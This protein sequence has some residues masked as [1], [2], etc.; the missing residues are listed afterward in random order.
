[1]I[2]TTMEEKK[3]PNFFAH[4][5]TAI[6]GKSGVSWYRILAEEKASLLNLGNLGL[7]GFL[8][9]RNS[10]R[11]AA[12]PSIESSEKSNSDREIERER[13]V[14]GK[15]RNKEIGKLESEKKGRATVNCSI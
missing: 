11:R 13:I 6:D 3:S 9:G 12:S 5:R 10:I 8:S 15:K 2:T 1:M 14:K 4:T 7:L